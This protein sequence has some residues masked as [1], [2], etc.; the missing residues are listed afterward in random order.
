M[1][2]NYGNKPSG[3]AEKN[4][5]NQACPFNLRSEL[6]LSLSNGAGSEQRRM[7]PIAELCPEDMQTAL[8]TAS[9]QNGR[10]RPVRCIRRQKAGR[11]S[12]AGVFA[13]CP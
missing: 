3:G 13:V 5:A 4:K 6:A 8:A 2:G 11:I 10:L 1:K 7:E 12:N 9:K